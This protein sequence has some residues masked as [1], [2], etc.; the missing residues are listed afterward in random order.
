MSDIASVKPAAPV[1]PASTGVSSLQPALPVKPH[2]EVPRT[3]QALQE[4]LDA[5]LADADTSLRFRVDNLSRRIVVT[6]VDGAG[7]VI[8]QIPGEASLAIARRLAATGSL[9][10]GRA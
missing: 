9:L 5:M 1:S 2:V 7:E 4:Q 10:D 8:M 6:V 3:P